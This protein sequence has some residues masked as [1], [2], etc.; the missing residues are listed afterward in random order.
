M[1]ELDHALPILLTAIA[2]GFVLHPGTVESDRRGPPSYRSGRTIPPPSIHGSGPET[3]LLVQN[4]LYRIGKSF[5]VQLFRFW[6]KLH[7]QT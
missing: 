1:A 6:L 2:Y 4:L 7:S 3:R 5:D